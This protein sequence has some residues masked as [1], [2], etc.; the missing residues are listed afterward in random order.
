M[1]TNHGLF[2]VGCSALALAGCGP[3]DIA[4]PGTGGNVTINNTTNNPPAPAPTPTPTSTLVTPA[5]ECPS[6]ADPQGL[7]NAGVITGPEGTWRVCRLPARFNVS[8]TLVKTP[9]VLYEINGRVDVGTDGGF[10]ASAADTNVTLTFE[11]GVVT[12]A[13]SSTAW[14]AVN[15][16]NRI[17]ASGTAT[18]PI[19]FTSLQNVRGQNDEAAQQQWGG[20]VLLGRAPITDCG[21]GTV[22]SGGTASTCQRQTEG[23]ASPALYGGTNAA[24]NSGTVRYVQIRYSGAVL[25]QNSE[26]QSLTTGGTGSGTQ[27]DY[28][29]SFNSSDD[30][31][32]LFGGVVNMKHLVL[33]GADD[34]MVDVD[35]GSQANLQFVLMIQRS[36]Q[37]D[38]LM[39]IDSN[40]NETDTPRTRLRLANFTAVQTAVSSNNEANAQ[41]SLFMRGNSDVELYNGVVVSPNNECIRM[42]RSGGANATT[43]LAR[44]VVMQCNATKYIG[45]PVSGGYTAAE[46]ATFFGSGSNG[47][48]DAF[49]PTLTGGFINGANETAV[50]AFNVTT[51]SSFFSSV[52]Y[53]GAVRDASDTWY[54]GW[55]CNSA[56]ANFGTTSR[57]CFAIPTT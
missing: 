15:R 55:T 18:Q 34:D 42:N 32:E 25:S 22:A 54:A 19:I 23:A 20:L 8:S 57:S 29:Q 38:G 12:Y 4:S 1:K 5:S 56:A 52:A 40:N 21:T 50:T 49:T 45:S 28:I 47:N 33:V 14:I 43:L 7:T 48:N 26:L 24:D 37:G 13:S 36:G 9:G 31:M 17:N 6:I 2:L 41:A 16:G 39:E 44:S 27:F 3:T 53:I 35:T 10:T 51:L 30:A 46:V 11:P